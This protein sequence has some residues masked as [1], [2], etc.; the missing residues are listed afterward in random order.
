MK[1]FEHTKDSAPA[2]KP[3]FMEAGPVKLEFDEAQ[4]QYT[5]L[6][7]TANDIVTGEYEPAS[8]QEIRDLGS[9][10]LKLTKSRALYP[11]QAE[12]ALTAAGAVFN[13][14]GYRRLVRSIIDDIHVH[15]GDTPL[16]HS[17]TAETFRII[18]QGDKS[19]SIDKAE[20]W[21]LIHSEESHGIYQ[22]EVLKHLMQQQALRNEKTNS[23]AQKA[24]AVENSDNK[25]Y[26]NVSTGDIGPRYDPFADEENDNEQ[27][28]PVQVRN[29]SNY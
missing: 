17:A 2:S 19:V 28:V 20:L 23:S 9:W 13:N 7:A 24:A 1:T 10:A 14:P 16:A 25:E 29:K 26:I 6:L 27:L 11:L 18:D 3:H 21:A 12:K 5:E 8:E 4:K 15:M 22:E